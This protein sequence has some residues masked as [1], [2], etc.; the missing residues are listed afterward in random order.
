MRRRVKETKGNESR[1]RERRDDQ[2][3][4]RSNT[5]RTGR[6][7]SGHQ[8]ARMSNEATISKVM[9]IMTNTII[10][11]STTTGFGSPVNTPPPY[12]TNR[13]RYNN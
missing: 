10:S 12:E 3:E 2:Q 5:R 7:G 13:K 1:A 6:R 11:Q 8:K 4:R 9:A